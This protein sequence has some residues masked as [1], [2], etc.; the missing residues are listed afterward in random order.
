M[1]RIIDASNLEDI[2]KYQISF[3]APNFYKVDFIT[4]KEAFLNDFDNEGRRLFSKVIVKA[5]YEEN[6]LVGFI[7][8]GK[9]SFTFDEQGNISFNDGYNV[10]RNF[11]F[12]KS[13]EEVGNKLLNLALKDFGE[14]KKVYAFFHY[15]GMSCFAR[16]GKL[17][18]LNHH[19]EEILLKNQFIIEHENVYYSSK[20]KGDDNFEL[21]LKIKDINIG[22][23]QNIDFIFDNQYVGA[24]E[25]HYVNDQSAYLRWIYIE[26]KF[27]SKGIGTKAIR[28]LKKWLFEK[29]IVR[30]DTD[31]ALNNLIAQKYYEKNDFVKEGI[32]RSY[33]K[34]ANTK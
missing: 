1:I 24:C 28:S 6:T 5:A 30:F 2:Y 8:Y 20:L 26:D 22:R 29:G 3:N 16:H 27:K 4:W 9:T 14:S 21:E 10:I 18:E 7:Q 32:T 13:K 23:H 12:D 15:F 31:T 25:I 17:F 19:I 34:L 11:Y 33:F